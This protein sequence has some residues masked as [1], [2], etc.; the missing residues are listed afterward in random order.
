[1]AARRHTARSF[2]MGLVR[3]TYDVGP[4]SFPSNPLAKYRRS[5][6]VLFTKLGHSLCS[7]P[8]HSDH[9]EA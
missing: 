2:I 6:P 1:M 4:G 7:C 3:G 5:D 9:F 8:K